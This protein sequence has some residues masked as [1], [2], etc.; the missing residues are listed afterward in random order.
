MSLSFSPAQGNSGPAGEAKKTLVLVSHTHW[1]REWYLTYQQYRFKLVRLVDRLL[2][3]LDSDEEYAFFMLDGPT[4]EPTW[5]AIFRRDGCWSGLGIS[6][7]T[8]SWSA[9]R[10]ISRI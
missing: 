4:G 2:A 7:P 5:N 8:S 9:A 10:L 6:W 1:D 3:I